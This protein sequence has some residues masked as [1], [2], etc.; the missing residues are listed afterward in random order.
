VL[1]QTANIDNEV[2][3][4]E[5]MEI[6]IVER[7]PQMDDTAAVSLLVGFQAKYAQNENIEST[8]KPFAVLQR[9]DMESFESARDYR[10]LDKYV[11]G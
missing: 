10:V 5:P 4:Y 8:L 1:Q 2:A 6:L 7:N 3:T 11:C 9:F